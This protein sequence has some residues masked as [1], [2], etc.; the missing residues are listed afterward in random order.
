[1]TQER[2]DEIRQRITENDEM[3]IAAL[4]RRLE[5]VTELWHLKEELGLEVAD[6]GREQRLRAHLADIN[7]GPLTR[8]G[9]DEIVT[10]L[11]DLTKRELGT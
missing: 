10:V 1:V 7:T 4:N 5:L 11:L 9:L 3:V 8:E 2:F 6:P